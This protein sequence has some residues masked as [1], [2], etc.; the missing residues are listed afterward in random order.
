LILDMTEKQRAEAIR[1]EFTAN[2]SHELKT[3][4]TVISGFAELMENGMV[5]QEEIP[6]FSRRIHEEATRLVLLI[7]DVMRLSQLDEKNVN[8]PMEKVNLM[9]A[10]KNVEARLSTL[11][12][13]KGLS[14]CVEGEDIFITG[15]PKLIDELISNLCENAI[16]YN[17]EKGSVCIRISQVDDRVVLSVSDTGIGVPAEYQDR[18]FERFFRVDKSHSKEISGTGLG[19]SIVKHI[20]NYHK[21]GISMESVVG[22]GTT[23]S[24]SFPK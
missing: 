19:L 7:E 9:E 14:L 8:L 1:R 6:L 24:V 5:K 15:V 10:A 16:K 22:E 17:R 12:M 21:A 11:A 13:Q 18:V 4:V 2:V 3:P 23:I 20:A